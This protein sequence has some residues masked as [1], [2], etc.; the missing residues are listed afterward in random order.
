M[1][2]RLYVS[3]LSESAT[4]ASLRGCFAVFGEVREIEFATERHA[5]RVPSSAFVTMM[6]NAAA[7]QAERAL[8]GTLHQGK[9]LMVTWAAG[10]GE[11][12]ERATKAAPERPAG[13][14]VTHQFRDRSGMTYDLDCGL[15]K[16]SVRVL[17]PPEDAIPEWR[18]EARSSDTQIA[19]VERAAPTR[20][21]AFSAVVEGWPVSTALADGGIDWASVERALKAVR[22][23]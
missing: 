17:F 9:T 16:L 8:N 20:Q 1:Q 11:S 23:L 15:Q 6:T 10:S 12:R 13:A 21:L 22:A 2:H 18:I 3:N 4:L 19:A 7:T 14:F 5:Q